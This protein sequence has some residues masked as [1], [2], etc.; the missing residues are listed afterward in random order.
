MV[1]LEAMAAG[2]PIVATE[3]GGVGDVVSPAEACLVPPED[4]G[5]FAASLR[6]IQSG[7]QRTQGLVA[8]ARARLEEHHG[9]EQW[10]DRHLAT[11]RALLNGRHTV[12]SSTQTC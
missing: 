11:Y 9:P 12:T 5:A 4:P 10:I 2:V 3:V 6:D 1:L 8:A 7:R